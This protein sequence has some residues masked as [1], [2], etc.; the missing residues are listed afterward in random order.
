VAYPDDQGSC[1]RCRAPREV[2]QL[3]RVDLDLELALAGGMGSLARSLDAE[4]APLAMLTRALEEDVAGPLATSELNLALAQQ[5]DAALP[6]VGELEGLLA[7]D[8]GA[9]ALDGI[10]LGTLV[11]RSSEVTELLRRGFVFL[12]R[13]KYA[14]ALEWWS[15]HRS[16]LD[17]TRQRLELLLLLLE[18]FTLGLAGEQKR[19]ATLR[20]QIRK[21]PLYLELRGKVARSR[22]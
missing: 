3:A 17:S 5:A 14:E 9:L 8:T 20:A 13:G 21:H 22:P 18:M 11:E 12:R 16:S 6:T 7:I 19:A 10:Q 1:P 2:G 15:L 4:A